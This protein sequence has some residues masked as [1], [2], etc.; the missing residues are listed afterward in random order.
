MICK[1]RYSDSEDKPSYA[2]TTA[3][4]FQ[5]ASRSR[6]EPTHQIAARNFEVPD[7][8]DIAYVLDFPVL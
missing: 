6:R 5:S 2:C 3:Q 1:L 8:S 7:E 4:E